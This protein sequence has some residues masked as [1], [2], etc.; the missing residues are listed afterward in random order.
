MNR[1]R[2]VPE[3]GWLSAGTPRPKFLVEIV[4]EKLAVTMRDEQ[5]R[6]PA[7]PTRWT[8]ARRHGLSN[9]GFR[10]RVMRSQVWY[11][12]AIAACPAGWRR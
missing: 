10:P 3:K 4:D 7:R 6:E 5:G 11:A 9:F 1:L 2:N 12:W 8:A